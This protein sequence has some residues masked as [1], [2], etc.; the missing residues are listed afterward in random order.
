MQVD[1]PS[2]T[3]GSVDWRA[4]VSGQ[5]PSV[6]VTEKS[7]SQPVLLYLLAA[8]LV[9]DL[10]ILLWR[11][12]ARARRRAEGDWEPHDNPFVDDPDFDA[13]EAGHTNT[14]RQQ[15]EFVGRH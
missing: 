13:V 2:L 7:S 4:T 8:I 15:P 11:I 9:I 6:T 14:A 10:L 12:V 3:I 1:V 5:G